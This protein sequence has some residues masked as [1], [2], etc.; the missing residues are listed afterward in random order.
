VTPSGPSKQVQLKRYTGRRDKVNRTAFSAF[1][2]KC[3]KMMVVAAKRV[4]PAS[5]ILEERDMVVG[6]EDAEVQLPLHGVELWLWRFLEKPCLG[7]LV[8][9]CKTHNLYSLS[10]A[11]LAGCTAW[12]SVKL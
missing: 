9:V 11:G 12:S 4:V 1:C 3:T 8:I 6:I 5:V 7:S 2:W 10:A